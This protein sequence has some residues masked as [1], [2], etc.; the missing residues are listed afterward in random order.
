MLKKTAEEIKENTEAKKEQNNSGIE[1]Q[2][3]Q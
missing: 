1:S 2:Q 3:D